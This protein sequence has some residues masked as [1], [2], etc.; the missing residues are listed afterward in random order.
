MFF[1][2]QGV[3]NTNKLNSGGQVTKKNLQR[4]ALFLFIFVKTGK[5]GIRPYSFDGIAFKLIDN[6]ITSSSTKA[7]IA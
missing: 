2:P 7:T 6:L 5:A 4:V 1:Y 3:E